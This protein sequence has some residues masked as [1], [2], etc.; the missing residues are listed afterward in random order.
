M[1]FNYSVY[2]ATINDFEKAYDY[3]KKALE[4]GYK[5]WDFIDKSEYL[6]LFRQTNEFKKLERKFR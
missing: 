1:K 6:N 5:N 2:Y 4:M 3:M